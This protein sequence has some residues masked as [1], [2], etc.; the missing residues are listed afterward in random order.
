M[1]DQSVGATNPKRPAGIWSE[2]HLAMTV[3]NLLTVALAGFG[4]LALLSA[5][6][7]IAA[8]LGHVSLLP[9]VMTSFIA[10][11]AIALVI[12]GPVIDAIGLRRTFRVI[13]IWLILSTAAAAAAPS[14]LMLVLARAIQGIGGGLVLA[15]SVA[16]IGLG[17]PPH[18]RA[19]VIVAQAAVFAVT[20][21]GG[22]AVAGA[23]LAFGGWRIIFI[24]QIPL[25]V[26][27]V[28]SGWTTLPGTRDRPARIKSDWRGVGLISLLILSS[29]VAVAQ[30][31]VRWWAVG[32]ALAAT[33]ALGAVYWTHARRVDAPVVAREHLTRFPLLPAHITG[34]LALLCALAVDNYLPFYVQTARGHSVEF[35]AISLVFLSAGWPLGSLIYSRRLK[36]W[37]DCDV[38]LLGCRLITPSIAVAG[39]TVAF[40]W[41]LALL[42]G[43]SVLIGTALG[44]V[45]TAGLMLLQVSCE[46]SEMGRVTS[47]QMFIRE[48]AIM[49]GLALTGAIILFV[50]EL[51]V[52]DVD[53]VRDVIAGNDLSLGPATRVA[54]RHGLAW[55]HVV[56]GVISIGGLMVAR[57]LVRRTPR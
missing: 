21:I 6:S 34:G 46:R 22:P 26:I 55:V 29:L 43:V 27:A 7:S 50:V 14:M 24:I 25:A 16:A 49:Y 42:F 47:V 2:S 37:R 52:G 54:I 1:S 31:G 41:P 4:S 23:L 35:A 18:L 57:S 33:A 40:N 36:D 32:V 5:L 19:R 10:T 30:I 45:T 3:A 12:A 15:V 44:L 8:D 51:E 20:G 56:T 13:G 9:W 28:A 17:Y 48:L 11:S 39:A 38:I 53:A